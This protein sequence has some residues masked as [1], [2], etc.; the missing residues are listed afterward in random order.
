MLSPALNLSQA[1][2]SG[3]LL[4]QAQ[5]RLSDIHYIIKNPINPQT[6][7]NPSHP[8]HNSFNPWRAE[9]NKNDIRTISFGI[10]ITTLTHICI[11]ETAIR[12]NAD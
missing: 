6:H 10:L 3:P 11:T 9:L 8:F 1:S 5:N 2:V 7:G 12:L 4:S